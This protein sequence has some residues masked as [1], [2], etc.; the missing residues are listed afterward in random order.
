[1]SSRLDEIMHAKGVNAAAL[2]R[3]TGTDP[4]TLSKLVT[5]KRK[6]ALHWAQKFAPHL[7]V[8]ADDLMVQIGRPI[9]EGRVD[10]SLTDG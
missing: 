6:M 4:S 9:P 1:M 10:P 8:T 2:A 3:V 5:G 7:Q